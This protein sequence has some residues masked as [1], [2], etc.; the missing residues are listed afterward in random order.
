LTGTV[1]HPSK[2]AAESLPADLNRLREQLGPLCGRS[3]IHLIVAFG[4]AAQGRVHKQSD[5]DL[6]FL[7]QTALDTLEITNRVMTLLRTHD[8]DVVDLRRASPLLA[9]EVVR[10]GQVLYE[11]HAGEYAE[12]CSLAHRRYVDTAKLRT[13]QREALARFLHVRSLA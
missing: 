4:S 13:A 2:T 12:F 3:D 8:I 9:M 11:R 5:L 6:A 1:K 10:K 7:G